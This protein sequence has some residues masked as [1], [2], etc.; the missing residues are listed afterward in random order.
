MDMGF[1][2]ICLFWTGAL[3]AGAGRGLPPIPDVGLVV[4]GG[5]VD[6][7]GGLAA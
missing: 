7:S 6:P 3:L 2:V 1:V 5:S 4:R